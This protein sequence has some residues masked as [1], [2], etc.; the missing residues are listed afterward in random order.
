[1]QNNV[2]SSNMTSAYSHSNL[3]IPTGYDETF[4]WNSY[5]STCKA[6]RAPE[7]IFTKQQ[8]EKVKE[9]LV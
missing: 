7:N 1:M 6:V 8:L 2:N 4:N 3:H 5:L 9:F